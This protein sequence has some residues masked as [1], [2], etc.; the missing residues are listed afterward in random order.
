MNIAYFSTFFGPM[1]ALLTRIRCKK[2][3]VDESTTL[4]KCEEGVGTAMCQKK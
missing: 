1:Q 3:V 4:G 2:E